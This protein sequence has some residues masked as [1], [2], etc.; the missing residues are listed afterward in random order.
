MRNEMA[1]ADAV[2]ARIVASLGDDRAITPPSR[3]GGGRFGANGL[4]VNGKLFAMISKGSLVVKLPR[5]R[6]AELV[7]AGT[8]TRF[9]PGH[10]RLMNEWVTISLERPRLWR[11]LVEE[12]RQFVGGNSRPLG[13]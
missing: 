9:D 11:E 7:A 8:G 12:A 10:G 3:A 6:A 1:D 13:R 5:A 2:F 4:K